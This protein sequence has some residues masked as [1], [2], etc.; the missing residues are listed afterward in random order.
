M[1]CFSILQHGWWLPIQWCKAIAGPQFAKS[2]FWNTFHSGCT[3]AGL[4]FPL[5][6]TQCTWDPNTE[7][8]FFMFFSETHSAA[9]TAATK[10]P[11]YSVEKTACVACLAPLRKSTWCGFLVKTPLSKLTY[12]TNYC[13]GWLAIFHIQRSQSQKEHPGPQLFFK[14]ISGICT[15][16]HAMDW[17]HLSYLHIE[18]VTSGPKP[19]LNSCFILAVTHLFKNNLRNKWVNY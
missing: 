13:Q 7:L 8:G 14:R 1:R 18:N 3:P 17:Q 16:L 10:A 6:P 19:S 2:T 4:T 9:C 12:A 5:G 11:R 15:P